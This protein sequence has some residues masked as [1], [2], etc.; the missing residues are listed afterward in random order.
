MLS[1]LPGISSDGSVAVV[2]DP[3]AGLFAQRQGRPRDH[4]TSAGTRPISARSL[5]VSV[6]VMGRTN[7]R[8]YQ[9]TRPATPSGVCCGRV[10]GATIC[11][12]GYSRVVFQVLVLQTRVSTQ[13]GP[14]LLLDMP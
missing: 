14:V 1:R 6:P 7:Q 8:A 11:C 10:V 5:A 2:S 4:L 9:S 13:S 3:E 12:L